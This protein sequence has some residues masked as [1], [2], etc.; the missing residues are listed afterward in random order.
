MPYLYQVLNVKER[1][2]II[3]LITNKMFCLCSPVEHAFE[4]VVEGVR[5]MTQLDDSYWGE[6]DCFV[7]YHFPSQPQDQPVAPGQPIHAGK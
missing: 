5:G 4:V 2:V 6:A 3:V 7:Q 1:N